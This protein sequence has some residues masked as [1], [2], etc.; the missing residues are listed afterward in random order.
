MDDYTTDSR[1]Y[2]HRGYYEQKKI[3]LRPLAFEG[4]ELI[5]DCPDA[6]ELRRWWR[7]T[8]RGNR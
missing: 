2:Y 8:I 4:G 3:K 5:I 7:E 6:R 1:G